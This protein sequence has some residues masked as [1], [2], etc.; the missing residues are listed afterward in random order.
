MKPLKRK[1][2]EGAALLVV[3][4]VVMAI[5]IMSLGF[6]SQS[7]VELACGQNMILRTQMDHLA[8]SALEHARGLILNPQDVSPEYWTGA[9]GVQLVAGSDDYYDVK[10]AR[11]DSSPTNR[12]N[13]IIGSRGYRL[14]GGET[15][16][17][18]SLSAELRLDP[19]IA[20]WT[21]DDTTVWSGVTISGDVYC[22]GTL[23]NSG[24]INGDVFAGSL[25]GS[26]TGQHKA[27]ADLSLAWPGLEVSNFSSQYYIDST[28]YSV[29]TVASGNYSDVNWG[30]S[31]S[32]PAGV[33][34]CN[35][36]LELEDEVQINGMLVV[37]GNLTVSDMNNVITAVKS[38]PALLVDGKVVIEGDNGELEVN[39]LAVV[40]G[41]MHVGLDVDDV[42]VLGGLFIEDILGET[43]KD[44]SG[45][46]NNGIVYN[47]PNWDAGGKIGRAPAFDGSN[48]Y[49]LVP[50]SSS[51]QFTNQLTIC[52]WI[53]GD[54][55]G[56]GSDV[57]VITRKGGS[58]PVNYQLAVKNGRV[59][60]MLDGFD[61]VGISGDT[62][63]NTGQWYHVSASWNGAVVKLYIDSE[64]DHYPPDARGGTIGTDTR[65]LYIGGRPGGDLFHGRIDD[66][67]IYNWAFNKEHVED[68]M[69]GST[70]AGL[71]GH[72]KLDEQG[73]GG[74]V[75]ITAFP[76]KAAIQTWPTAG[77]AFRWNP[78]AGAFFKSIERQ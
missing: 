25:S 33:Y 52:A 50:N 38:F 54:T 13:Y 4:F 10:I 69:D 74:N 19:C 2:R 18:S 43:T 64:L 53:R 22:N 57:D 1:E 12:C 71:V 46:F 73:N 62:V 67:Q 37:N 31:G 78:A 35:G 61:T 65:P 66:V 6:L 17:R 41:Q 48:D 47:D 9:N 15:V 70:L 32:N 36:D 51:L 20:F 55:W 21:G 5:T 76:D 27:T 58:T 29:Q 59:T 63:L 77:N 34:Y 23:T 75:T 16:G 3:L 49:I 24:V 39:G 8:E 56:S 72:W 30:S 60:L 42:S 40:K 26:V 28:A 14:D 44:S 45:N 11:D 68:I 7:D